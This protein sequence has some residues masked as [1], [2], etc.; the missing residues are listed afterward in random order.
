MQGPH[1]RK[2]QFT[3][4]I[5]WTSSEEVIN[6]WNL[7]LLIMSKYIRTIWWC[8][9]VCPLIFFAMCNHTPGT[10][11]ATFNDSTLYHW[12]LQYIWLQVIKL[13]A[14]PRRPRQMLSDKQPSLSSVKSLSLTLNM[15]FNMKSTPAWQ[16]W[17]SNPVRAT[18][19]HITQPHSPP[20]QLCSDFDFTEALFR[21]SPQR[22]EPCSPF[23]SLRLTFSPLTLFMFHLWLSNL[24]FLSS[25]L[26]GESWDF[27]QDSG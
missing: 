20:Y 10:C 26:W 25:A 17:Y 16:V 3:V 8:I 21:D 22:F 5:Q 19:I 12:K 11:Y 7:T 15:T 4:A 13:F 6:R 23:F 2:K 9:F 27:A 24:C 1:G 14:F 18:S